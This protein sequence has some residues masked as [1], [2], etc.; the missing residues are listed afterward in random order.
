MKL[1]LLTQIVV[2]ILPS[3][4]SLPTPDM[5]ISEVDVLVVKQHQNVTGD[6]TLVQQPWYLILAK[7]G[8]SQDSNTSKN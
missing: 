5:P 8:F 6:W 4:C 1:Y 7:E 2:W 3:G